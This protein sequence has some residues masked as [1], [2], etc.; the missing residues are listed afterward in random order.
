MSKVVQ[1]LWFDSLSPLQQP[2]IET[3]LGLLTPRQIIMAGVGALFSYLFYVQLLQ[4]FPSIDQYMR[5]GLATIPFILSITITLRRVKTIPPENYLFYLIF[6][7]RLR[8][9]KHSNSQFSSQEL[10]WKHIP[11]EIG[12]VLSQ[13]TP[14]VRAISVKPNALGRVELIGTLRNP[15]TGRPMPNTKLYAFI[16]N[17]VFSSSSDENGNYIISFHP[18][19]PG[20]YH[21][22]VAVQGFDI[23]VDSIL[24][25]VVL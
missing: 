21:M 1:T 14:P 9:W 15:K 25:N 13:L 23:P 16:G 6:R 7:R 11:K 22:I 4:R 18:K 24:V 12:Q 8:R 3:P 5:I 2:L 19:A 17:R 10:R 20:S